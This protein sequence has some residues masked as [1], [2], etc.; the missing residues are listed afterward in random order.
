MKFGSGPREFTTTHWSLIAAVRENDEDKSDARRAL[1]ELCRAYWYPLYAFARHRGGSVEDAQD[2]TQAFLARF[3]ETGG[4]TSAR[5]QRGRFRSYLLGAF[6]HFLANDW[7]R[8]RTLK[9]GGGAGILEW[10]ALEP[11]ARYA[12]EPRAD[13][14]PDALF[15]RD[16][17]RELTARALATLRSDAETAGRT[18][19]FLALQGSLTGTEID[20]AEVA[21]ELAMSEGAVKVAIHRLRQRYRDCLRNEIARTVEDASEVD[22]EMRHLVAVIRNS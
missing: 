19:L 20:R 17:A 5:R 22:D 7:H 16:W 15:D 14:D 1:E 9:R 2:L 3:I 18:R 12:L 13:G 6:K 11:E 8:A 4:F 10:D 21:R